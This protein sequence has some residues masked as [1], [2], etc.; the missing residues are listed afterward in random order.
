MAVESEDLLLEDYKQKIAYLTAH[1]T[2]M[3]ARFNYFVAIETARNLP[4]PNALIRIPQSMQV[5]KT[6]L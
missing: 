5:K 1:F 3:W 6:A 2:R 4:I